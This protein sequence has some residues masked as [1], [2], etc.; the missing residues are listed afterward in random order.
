MED[1]DKPKKLRIKRGR[2]TPAMAQ[3][4]LALLWRKDVSAAVM[5]AKR[6]TPDEAWDNVWSRVRYEARERW[7]G[8][9]ATHSIDE[10]ERLHAEVEQQLRSDFEA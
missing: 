5:A 10:R 9:R 4:I 8:V 2:M 1:R 6:A 3:A 7:Q